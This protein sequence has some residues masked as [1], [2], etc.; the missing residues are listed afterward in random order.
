LSSTSHF[1]LKKKIYT[2]THFRQSES[3]HSSL[4]SSRSLPKWW[5]NRAGKCAIRLE[6]LCGQQILLYKK[7]DL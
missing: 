7:A 2:L 5:D 3:S 1:P 6:N 4:A